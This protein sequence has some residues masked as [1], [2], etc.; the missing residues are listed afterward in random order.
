[1]GNEGWVD[2]W[3]E[4][5]V[6]KQVVVYERGWYGYDKGILS[7]IAFTDASGYGETG[8]V[9]SLGERSFGFGRELLSRGLGIEMY[10]YCLWTA[11]DEA[12]SMQEI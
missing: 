11:G 4:G 8:P 12:I 3:M 1:M 5:C 2:G 7:D 6:M 10:G 9:G